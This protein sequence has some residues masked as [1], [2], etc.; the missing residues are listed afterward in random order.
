[1]GRNIRATLEQYRTAMGS[2]LRGARPA[3]F[4]NP[5]ANR[6]LSASLAHLDVRVKSPFEEKVGVLLIEELSRNEVVSVDPR[7]SETPRSPRVAELYCNRRLERFIFDFWLRLENRVAVVECD[8]ESWHRG[9]QLRRDARKNEFC[10]EL[11]WKM[12]RI[13]S[14]K[15][16]WCESVV[17]I[18][19]NY[20]TG[21]LNLSQNW[22]MPW[23]WKAA[24]V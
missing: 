22:T 1:M 24:T 23:N 2:Y 15:M 19:V 20:L 3:R 17:A 10:S 12:F 13:P 21:E 9:E 6:L 8:G 4:K 16:R 7:V 5:S 11:G 18:A 14:G